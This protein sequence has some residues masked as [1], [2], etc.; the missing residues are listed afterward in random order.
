MFV[1]ESGTF[2][3]TRCEELDVSGPVGFVADF[4]RIRNESRIFQSITE[5]FYHVS[6][7]AFQLIF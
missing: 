4:D 6:L 2:N 5:D 1:L 7:V 3:F